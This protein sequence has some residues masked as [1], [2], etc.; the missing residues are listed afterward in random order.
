[1]D[2]LTGGS[3]PLSAGVENVSNMGTPEVNISYS[4]QLHFSGSAA[5]REEIEGIMESEQDK[6][7]R[8][9]NQWAKENMRFNFTR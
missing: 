8:M 7:N 6:F 3:E 1:M 5:S 4:P 9:M 2:G